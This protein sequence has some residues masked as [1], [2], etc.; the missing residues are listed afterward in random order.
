MGDFY[1]G[2]FFSSGFFSAII[3]TIEQTLVKLRSFTER[4][5]F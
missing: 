2:T 5:R 3:N 1:G 4:R